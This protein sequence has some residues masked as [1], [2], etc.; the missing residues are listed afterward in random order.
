[1]KLVTTQYAKVTV[2][3]E[4]KYRKY[5]ISQIRPDQT[6]ELMLMFGEGELFNT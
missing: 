4:D 5:I 2:E 1:M 3:R 6:A